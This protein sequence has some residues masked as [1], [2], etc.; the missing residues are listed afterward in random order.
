MPPPPHW[1]PD[2]TA[3][4]PALPQHLHPISEAEKSPFQLLG[5]EITM[6][7]L[8]LEPGF[9]QTLLQLDRDSPPII[10]DAH[11]SRLRV[12]PQHK[13]IEAL[14]ACSA[15]VHPWYPIFRPGFSIWYLRTISGPLRPSCDSGLAL[16]VAAVGFLVAEDPVTGQGPGDYSAVQFLEAALASLPAIISSSTIGGIHSLLL[17]AVYHSCALRPCQ[18]YDY[19]TIASFKI[20]NLLKGASN[21]DGEL[22]EQINRSFWA[23]L[24][25][26][27]EIRVQFDLV[28]SGIQELDDGVPLPDSR[29]TWR[30]NEDSS[31]SAEVTSPESAMESPV[32]DSTD[33]VQ[34]YFLAEIAMRRMLSRCNTAIR[35]TTSGQIVYASGIATELESQLE[36]W[37]SYLPLSVRFDSHQDLDF[38]LLASPSLYPNGNKLSNFLRVQYYCC[39]ISIYWPA[40]YQCVQDDGMTE[41]LLQHCARFFD[42]YVQL[43]PSILMAVRDCQVNRWTLYASIF[44]TSLAVIRAASVS[45]MQQ[46][47]GVDWARLFRCLQSTQTVDRAIAEAT[48]SLSMLSGTLSRRLAAFMSTSDQNQIEQ[49]RHHAEA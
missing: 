30:F 7:G 23:T 46:D 11:S 35:R 14:A 9:A 3:S 15:Y 29:R 49:Q 21:M 42:A 44:M 28:G 34:S 16:L 2:P 48:P 22:H 18:A 39:K 40:A 38:D 17:L 5:G 8:G 13:A 32:S 20:Q 27:S 31:A 41:E 33:S 26:E 43:M 37:Y 19:L 1:A 12:I 24:L 25:F 47:C 6:T 45:R 36:S 10:D 4:S